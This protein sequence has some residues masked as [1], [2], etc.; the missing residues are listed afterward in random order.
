MKKISLALILIVFLCVQGCAMEN[1]QVAA[2]F[3]QIK[4]GDTRDSLITSMGPP[5]DREYSNFLGLSHETL[6]W[7]TGSANYNVVLLNDVVI[8]KNLSHCKEGHDY[9]KK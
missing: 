6:N 1:P 7:R 3:N 2:H 8:A 9:S 4:I 5:T